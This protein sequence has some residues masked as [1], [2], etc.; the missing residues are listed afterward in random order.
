MNRRKFVQN[1]L[2]AFPS[3]SGLS[4]LT[5]SC[6]KDLINLDLKFKGKVAIIGAGIS[7]LHAALLL[8]NYGCEV[9]HLEAGNQ[10]GGR[11]KT[12]AD[13]T[14]FPVELGAEAIHGKRNILHDLA[15]SKGYDLKKDERDDYYYIYNVLR[16]EEQIAESANFSLINQVIE[17]FGNYTGNDSSMADYLLR[18]GLDPGLRPIAEALI[19]NDY[20][21]SNARLSIKGVAVDDA[22]WTSGND[23]YF[24]SQGSFTELMQKAYSQEIAQ[25]QL[26]KRVQKIDYQE[27]GVI[28]TTAN[29]EVFNCDRVLITVPISILK[30]GAII[31]SPPLPQRK[32][33][34]L[35]SMEMDTGIKIILKFSQRFWPEDMSS[36]LGGNLVPEYWTTGGSRAGESNLL[37]AFVMGEKAE[38]LALLGNAAIDAVL[39]ELNIIFSTNLATSA[40]QDS[41]IMNWKEQPHIQGAYSY[42]KAGELNQRKTYAEPIANVCFFAGEAANFTGHAATVHGAME[43]AFHSAK[44]ILSTP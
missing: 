4:L 29:N 8:K 14:D 35:Q 44:L 19:G 3:I 26:N 34:A 25:V 15:T 28:I 13:F 12:L 36:I 40:I 6:K 16:K 31:F 11:I 38:N 32:L 7:G 1:T 42:I 41:Y 33:T 2:L 37:T 27:S 24:F 9:I 39:S 30:A 17:S 18:I 23:N 22:Q 20:G 10:I 5:T 21:T 43:S